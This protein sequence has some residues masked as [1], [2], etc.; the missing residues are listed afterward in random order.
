MR[1]TFTAR[2]SGSRAR[3]GGALRHSPCAHR[4]GQDTAWSTLD[5][6]GPQRDRSTRIPP[7]SGSDVGTRPGDDRLLTVVLP[8]ALS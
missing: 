3:P 4:P 2:R 8:K 7:F 6:E 5:A 1:V